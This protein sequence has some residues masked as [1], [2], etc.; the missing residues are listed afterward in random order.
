MYLHNIK[1]IF[2]WSDTLS[3]LWVQASKMVIYGTFLKIVIILLK[4][5]WFAV[6]CSMVWIMS[7]IESCDAIWCWRSKRPTQSC[8]P[9]PRPLHFSWEWTTVKFQ[10]AL[11]HWINSCYLF[12]LNPENSLKLKMGLSAF[13]QLL[14]FDF[15]FCSAHNHFSPL[16]FNYKPNSIRCMQFPTWGQNL[17][18]FS[19]LFLVFNELLDGAA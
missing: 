6:F 7:R 16:G 17:W 9:W 12:H 2:I 8:Y 15:E 13:G 11:I 4:T 14:W 18:I 10:N 1:I 3:F 19:F 5:C